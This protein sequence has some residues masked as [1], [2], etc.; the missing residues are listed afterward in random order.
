MEVNCYRAPLPK[1]LQAKF[2]PFLASRGLREEGDAEVYALMTDELDRIMAC[3]VRCGNLLK[4]FAV[5]PEAEG[6]GACAQIMTALTEEAYGRGVTG[7][8]LCTK[9]QN[10]SMFTSLGFYELAATE[11]AV[12]LENTPRGLN[13]FLE[14]LPHPGGTVGAVVCNCNPFTLGHRYL[15]ETAAAQC[16]ALH[17]FVLTDEM[18]DSSGGDAS[19]L[20]G[21][22]SQQL[23][24]ATATLCEPR[25]VPVSFFP[26]QE[27]LELVR[28]GTADIKNCFVHQS[29]EYLI[30]RGTF[31]AYFIKETG[32]VETVRADLDITLFGSRIAPALGI[33]KR[34]VGTEPF[35]P[36]TKAYNERLKELL[37]G[38][39]IE[40]I[41]IPRFRDISAS[42]VRA[43]MEERN[44]EAT[45]A[46]V[47]E[48]TY[49]SILR[50]LN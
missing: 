42:R 49:A 23:P 18:K 7:L 36:V 27:R 45:R 44:P 43:L 30:S 15:I 3:G 39:G 28:R 22:T 40:L 16:D 1:R 6:T 46:L 10:K 13:K 14:S 29:G 31:P 34:F 37:P 50:H 19:S 21:R 2:G 9:P 38:Y 41:E 35:C 20:P 8:F 5:A 32:K 33:T 4:Q 25:S 48:T 47:P 17:V 26:A 24:G 12:Y 11:D